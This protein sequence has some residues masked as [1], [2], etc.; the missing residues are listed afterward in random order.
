MS[1]FLTMLACKISSRDKVLDSLIEIMEYNYYRLNSKEGVNSISGDNN[2][3]VVS[4]VKNGWVQVFCPTNLKDILALELSK[5][6]KSQV[7]FFHIHEGRFW[8]YE[9]FDAGRLIDKYNP[10]PDYWND[11]IGKNDEKDWEGNPILIGNIFNISPRRIKP[12][13]I[14]HSK[15]IDRKIKAFPKDEF[16]LQSEWSMIDFQNKLGIIYPEFDK[17][18][19]LNLVK[20]LFEKK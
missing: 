14:N 16:P 4:N 13:L 9:L 18:K 5:K 15:I 12:Y 8:M 7:F 10:Y 17:P 3:F 11:F 20:L 6:L 19:T 1:L 2:Q